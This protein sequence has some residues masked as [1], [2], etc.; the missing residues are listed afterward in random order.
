MKT[1]IAK[2]LVWILFATAGIAILLAAVPAKH[3]CR[4]SLVTMRQQTDEDIAGIAFDGHSLWVTLDGKGLIYEMSPEDGSIRRQI[5]F[6]SDANGGSA[7]DGKFLWQLAY[8]ERIIYKV[9]V[10]TGHIAGSIPTPNHGQC[11]GM[12]FDGKYLWVANFDDEKIYQVD[13]NHDGRIVSSIDGYREVTG[14]AWDGQHLWMGLLMTANSRKEDIPH[15]GFVE[16]VDLATKE[17][18]NA[19]AITGVGSGTSDWTPN[20]PHA[21]RYWWYDAYHRKIVKYNLD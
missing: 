19:V 13:Q 18:L 4:P 11:S 17:P 14:L 2:P 7:W 6:P 16:Q 8:K 3:H 20:Q 5:S 12:T 1:F 21:G 10:A 9:D 15:T